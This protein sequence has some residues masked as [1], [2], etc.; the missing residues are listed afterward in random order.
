MMKKTKHHIIPRSRGGKSNRENII[1]IDGKLHDLYHQLFENKT[2]DEVIRFL[3][4]YFWKEEYVI[5]KKGGM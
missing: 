2:P 3:N 4:E 5:T 1:R